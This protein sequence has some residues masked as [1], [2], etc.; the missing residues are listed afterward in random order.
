[1]SSWWR[2][3]PSQTASKGDAFHIIHKKQ[4]FGV[5]LLQ[6]SQKSLSTFTFVQGSNGQRSTNRTLVMTVNI[7][8]LDS[9]GL[10][11]TSADLVARFSQTEG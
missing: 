8:R 1:M 5:P 9:I 10:Y 4:C 6:R 2:V 3:K 7:P 11:F